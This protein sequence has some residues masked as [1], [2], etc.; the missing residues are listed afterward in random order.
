MRF[1]L[2]LWF[3][4]TSCIPPYAY[5]QV[6]EVEGFYPQN[7]SAPTNY[8]LNKSCAKSTKDVVASAPATL[9]RRSTGGLENGKDCAFDATALGQTI[10][11]NL[12]QYDPGLK[13]GYCMASFTYQYAGTAG[14]YRAY[15]ERNGIELP[16]TSAS[17]Q[18]TGIDTR[19]QFIYFPCGDLTTA[20]KPVI[21]SAVANPGIIYTAVMDSGKS[22]QQTIIDAPEWVGSVTYNATGTFTTASTSFV[23]ATTTAAKTHTGRLVD[24]GGN[25]IGF[26]IPTMLPGLYVM[27]M[28][29]QNISVG[30]GASPT[31]SF[32]YASF[33][34]SELP[35][36][37]SCGSFIGGGNE[38]SV[39]DASVAADFSCTYVVPTTLTNKS[40]SIKFRTNISNASLNVGTNTRIDVFRY[41]TV[42]SSVQSVGI[43]EATQYVGEVFPVA[44]A[45]C[46]ANSLLANGQTVSR[47]A[48][49]ELFA[50]IGTTH[51]QGDGSTTF[52]IPDY[53]GRFIRGVDGGSGNDGDAATRTAMN[54]GGN[55]GNT[56]GSIQGDA[57]RNITGTLSNIA[58]YAGSSGAFTDAAAAGVHNDGG[59][60]G[61]RSFSF[62]A[63]NQVPTGSDVRPRNAYVNFC[64]RTR[65]TRLTANLLTGNEVTPV[66]SDY[67][68]L[69]TD[70][71]IIVD[72]ISAARTITLPSAASSKGKIYE[73]TNRNGSNQV[74]ITS[75]SGN[76]CGQSSIRL[77]S[78]RDTG[79]FQSD[80]VEWFGLNNSCY[81]I[82]RFGL[83]T[84]NT[85]QLNDGFIQNIT[86][87]GNQG[88]LNFK[89]GSFSSLPG[90]SY[91][92]SSDYVRTNGAVAN[93]AS[94]LLVGCADSS[95]TQ[96]STRSIT[97]SCYGPR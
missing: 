48:N 71:H 61:R 43:P 11:W 92:C 6:A 25:Q 70:N 8:V 76:I 32:G 35:T 72:T 27:T 96:L 46:P 80:G 4:I 58:A 2:V 83:T 21:V 73:I 29:G 38:N 34:Y 23:S 67:S 31:N 17:L 41:P 7:I 15:I 90:C 75:V 60:A 66:A 5:A 79:K 22:N 1:L 10:K 63:S 36:A 12:R 95:G 45:T 39:H 88:V 28:S 13:G 49:P 59:G 62:N 3:T 74:I 94:Q 68:V 53:R 40:F 9:T 16:S 91:T 93:T 89:T 81:V 52:H 77:S 54:P 33:S 64:I 65:T 19:E 24:I 69:P 44:T 30:G 37:D 18:S 20:T 97:G 47:V 85:P 55:T 51:G 82:Y 87:S 42:N 78:V 14:D 26:T 86:A 84:P 56:V 57:I 50:A